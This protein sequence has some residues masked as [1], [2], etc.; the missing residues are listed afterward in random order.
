MAMTTHIGIHAAKDWEGLTIGEV[1]EF[2]DA[3]RRAKADP[4]TLVEMETKF[5]DD[6]AGCPQSELVGLR[7]RAES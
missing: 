5:I 2:A 6:E 1:I 3:A 7:V 4:D